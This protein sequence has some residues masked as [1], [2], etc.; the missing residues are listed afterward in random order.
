MTITH[1]FCINMSQK[2]PWSTLEHLNIKLSVYVLNH[3]FVYFE[4]NK[5]RFV[6]SACRCLALSWL[7]HSGKT[8][9]HR[10]IISSV[11]EIL[12]TS[13]IVHFSR[14]HI[15]KMIVEIRETIDFFLFLGIFI[16]FSLRVPPKFELNWTRQWKSF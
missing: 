10:I 3:C 6:Q 1:L 2:W 7:P 14:I 12:A 13:D 4:L 5:T 16:C 15:L 8:Y 9:N 11:K